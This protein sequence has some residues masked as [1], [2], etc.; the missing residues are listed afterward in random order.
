[1]SLPSEYRS[2]FF[3]EFPVRVQVQGYPESYHELAEDCGVSVEEIAESKG[4]AGKY[5]YSDSTIWLCREMVE[6]I[7]LIRDTKDGGC[8]I[9]LDTD[10][11]IYVFAEA[12]DVVSY[13]DGFLM[14]AYDDREYDNE[15]EVNKK[16]KEKIPKNEE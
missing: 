13:I 12:S 6:G 14:L 11:S 8:I 4:D 1:M 3:L 2:I 16:I 10:E 15:P 7:S 5:S 9:D